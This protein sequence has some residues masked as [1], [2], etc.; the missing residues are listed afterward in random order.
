M[1]LTRTSTRISL[2]VWVKV[3]GTGSEKDSVWS[4]TTWQHWLRQY[5]NS[6]A[7]LFFHPNA[8]TRQAS[9]IPAVQ[10]AMRLWPPLT[11]WR[12]QI[13]RHKA[14]AGAKMSV[15]L[16]PQW[17]SCLSIP[18]GGA[19]QKGLVGVESREGWKGWLSCCLIPFDCSV[20]CRVSVGAEWDVGVLSPCLTLPDSSVWCVRSSG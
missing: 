15:F 19:T 10:E 18:F 17:E 4:T 9:L 8:D 12:A 14:A 1:L 11:V 6:R 5:G 7:T 20:W 16:R 2:S 13:Y 3:L